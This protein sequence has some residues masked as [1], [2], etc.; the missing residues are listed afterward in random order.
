MA[1]WSLVLSTLGNLACNRVMS[2]RFLWGGNISIFNR[3]LELKNHSWRL[4]DYRMSLLISS[5]LSSRFLRIAKFYLFLKKYL[6]QP[7]KWLPLHTL[8]SSRLIKTAVK[9]EGLLWAWLLFS[10]FLTTFWLLFVSS[11]EN[12]PLRLWARGLV[13]QGN[14]CSTSQLTTFLLLLS[15]LL[16]NFLTKLNK[17]EAIERAYSEVIAFVDLVKSLGK[18]ICSWFA[19]GI[20]PDCA[21]LAKAGCLVG[22]F[23]CWNR[24]LLM[25]G[26]NWMS[27]ILFRWL[28]YFF[29][30]FE[31]IIEW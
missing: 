23:T 2:L 11:S 17:A 28:W 14:S 6:T 5:R 22:E 7:L 12:W 20:S 13:W 29:R 18:I 26:C 4:L 27:A 1:K 10:Y 15:Y 16:S 19:L 31:K 24:L 21:Y 3:L 8:C 9:T 30:L 25:H